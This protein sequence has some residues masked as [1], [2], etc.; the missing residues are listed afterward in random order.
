MQEREDG[1]NALAAGRR[2]DAKE[3]VKGVSW[4]K[5]ENRWFD[6][7]FASEERVNV[8]E[9]G[10]GV[11]SRLLEG[12]QRLLSAENK[13]WEER[14]SGEGQRVDNNKNWAAR[15]V[16]V[17]CALV[18]VFGQRGADSTGLGR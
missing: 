16:E 3:R 11:P 8:G 17:T 1:K 13:V 15:V 14:V 10:G 4:R 6:A 18:S 2:V 12:L 5:Y 9:K 7:V